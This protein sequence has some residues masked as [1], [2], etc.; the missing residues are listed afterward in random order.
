MLVKFCFIYYGHRE[1]GKVDERVLILS[2]PLE[3]VLM[4]ICIWVTQLGGWFLDM[5]DIWFS[6]SKQCL[7]SVGVPTAIAV[8]GDDSKSNVF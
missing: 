3:E 2:K 8:P 4:L 7:N 1:G 5:E 6:Q